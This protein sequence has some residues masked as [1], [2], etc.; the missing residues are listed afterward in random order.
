MTYG[1]VNSGDVSEESGWQ[2]G[3]FTQRMTRSHPLSNESI[4]LYRYIFLVS[5][6]CSFRNLSK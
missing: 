5:E 4:T 2:M 6:N 1:L 3:I